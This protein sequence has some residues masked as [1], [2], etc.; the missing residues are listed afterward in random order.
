MSKN[1]TLKK[2]ILAD[3]VKNRESGSLQIIKEKFEGIE[4]ILSLLHTDPIKGIQESS[5]KERRIVYGENK[6]PEVPSPSFFSFWWDALQDKTLIILSIAAVISIVLGEAFPV[7]GDR[8]TGWFE[9]AAILMAVFI[10]SLV[11]AINDWTKDKK[12]RKLTTITEDRKI[13]VIREGLLKSISVHSIVVG[14]LVKLET[15][16]FIPAD[17]LYIEGQSKF[18]IYI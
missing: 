16:D 6:L 9:G 10:V 4:G 5:L 17:M 14:D 18:L 11:T 12:F 1:W 8:A 15:G 3:L 7:D 2:Q 13:K